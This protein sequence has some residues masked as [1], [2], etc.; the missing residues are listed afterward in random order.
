M[1]FAGP[2]LSFDHSLQQ[3]RG[4]PESLGLRLDIADHL[5]I[6]KAVLK[7]IKARPERAVPDR[8]QLAVERSTLVVSVDENARAMGLWPDY[9]AE[10][11]GMEHL[12]HGARRAAERVSRLTHGDTSLTPCHKRENTLG[13]YDQQSARG[14]YAKITLWRRWIYSN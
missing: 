11:P 3:E 9:A 5:E 6:T 1:E 14:D 7:A 12:A 13:V 10:L 4:I 8:E 2:S